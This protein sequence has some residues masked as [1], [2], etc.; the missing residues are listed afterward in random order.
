MYNTFFK[1]PPIRSDNSLWDVATGQL[2]VSPSE[3]QG[4][5]KHVRK[6]EQD[7]CSIIIEMLISKMM[8]V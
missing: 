5:V 4:W 7:I 8:K 2:W 1:Y 6:F 3:W